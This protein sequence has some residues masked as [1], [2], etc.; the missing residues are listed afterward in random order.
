MCRENYLGGGGGNGNETFG[1]S[2][3]WF[4]GE[5]T[6]SFQPSLVG[7]LGGSDTCGWKGTPEM[8]WWGWKG[9]ISSGGC[10]WK[11]PCPAIFRK[12]VCK[13]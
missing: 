10:G 4:W 8:L 9:G 3:T 6:T 2:W 7:I 5:L 12:P 1:H 13:S 11:A